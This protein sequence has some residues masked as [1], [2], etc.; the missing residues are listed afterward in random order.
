METPP[1]PSSFV[2]SDGRLHD[3]AAPLLP[4]GDAALRWG[5]GLFE[6]IAAYG[7]LLFALERHLARLAT[8]AERLGLA[9]PRR[10][11]VEEGAALLLAANRLQDS[12]PARLRLTLTGGTPGQRARGTSPWFLEATPPPPHA[13]AARAVL[14][15]WTRNERSALAGLKTLSYGDN[16]VALRY[17]AERDADEALFLNT[18]GELCEGA[19]SNV[20]VKLDGRWLTPPLDSGCLPGVTRAL[21]LEIAA[22][23]GTPI[24]EIPVKVSEL[25]EVEAALLSST[26]RGVQPLRRLEG[27]PLPIA[28]EAAAWYS[29][30]EE[31][32]QAG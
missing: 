7:G 10:A 27:R 11:E 8:G 21:L 20:F 26:F 23:G 17:A 30:Y 15:P 29:R 19:W 18:R 28:P 6:S 24:E 32:A 14:V 3:A 1:P 9:L 13:S 25:R 4:L 22:A 16:P 12:R 2:Y 5:E 31:L